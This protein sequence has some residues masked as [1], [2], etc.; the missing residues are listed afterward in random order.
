MLRAMIVED[1]LPFRELFKRVFLNK[2][3]SLTLEEAGNA[4]EALQIIRGLSPNLIFLDILLPGENGLEV[5]QKIKTYF[6]NT[7]IAMLT[8]YDSAS[9]RRMAAKFGVDRFFIKDSLNWEEIKEWVISILDNVG[10]K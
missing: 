6:P 10:K 3:P 7:R 2:F 1:E 5:A 4:Q 9:N 8:N